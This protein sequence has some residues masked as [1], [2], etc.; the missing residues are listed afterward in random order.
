MLDQGT[1]LLA[2]RK[3]LS[4]GGTTCGRRA[5][6]ARQVR[7]CRPRGIQTLEDTPVRAVPLLE[8]R[9]HVLGTLTAPTDSNAM[10][11]ARA[12]NAAQLVERLRRVGTLH[13]QPP[14]AVPALDESPGRERLHDDT[15]ARGGAANGDAV[16][17]GDAVNP[18]QGGVEVA[19]RLRTDHRRPVEA[20]PALDEGIGRPGLVIGAD[21]NAVRFTRAARGIEV[22]AYHGSARG[23]CGDGGTAAASARDHEN[24]HQRDDE[25]DDREH[26]SRAQPVGERPATG[27]QAAPESWATE[28]ASGL[29]NWFTRA[30]ASSAVTGA[31][32]EL[33]A[34]NR[35]SL[36]A[37][38]RSDGFIAHSPQFDSEQF[39]RT[40]NAFLQRRR[41]DAEQCG[42]L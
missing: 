40:L 19:H 41:P 5:R 12:G 15:R 27:Q 6:D 26:E 32:A 11:G 14:L 25:S 3:V 18:V 30:F 10:S 13:D 20:V 2:M 1:V 39:H 36:I 29:A 34:W 42:H 16:R 23:R 38:S 28:T 37:S 7:R 8:E 33:I 35:R 17:G 4:D 21:G 31:A 22:A 9:V 24:G